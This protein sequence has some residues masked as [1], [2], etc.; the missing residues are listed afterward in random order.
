MLGLIRRNRPVSLRKRRR[1]RRPRHARGLLGDW[2]VE[3]STGV[4]AARRTLRYLRWRRGGTRYELLTHG[5]EPT[6]LAAPEALALY[7][8]RWS[9]ER[10]SFDLKEV[11]TLNR[12]Y[13]ANPNAVAMQVYAAGLVYSAMRVAQG[14]VAA[15]ARIAPEEISPAAF[16]PKLAA[17]CLAYVVTQVT[18]HDIRRLNPRRRLRIPDWRQARWASV[19]L[20][21]IPVEPRRGARR[22]RRFRVTRRTWTSF[23]H[24]A[25]GRKLTRLS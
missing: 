20:A 11:L 14:E 3:A 12:V 2:L 6:R 9:I 21:T 25:G 4:S 19:P 10:M 5:L 15:A 17:P 24:V 7:A 8:A 18:V 16:Y 22:H 1:L 23:A 13:A